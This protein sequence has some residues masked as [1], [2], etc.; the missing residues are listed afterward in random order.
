MSKQL[1]LID[2][3]YT[4]FYRFFATL[5]WV[6]LSDPDEYKKYKDDKTYDWSQ[7]T[8][9]IDKYKKM[10]LESIIKLIKKKSF[11]NSIIIFCMDSPRNTLWRNDIISSYKSDRVDL[12][13]K[14]DFKPTFQY[15][16]DK[17][18]PDIIKDH[19]NI[20]KLKV[21]NT[22]ADDIIA[23]ITMYL[24][25]NNPDQSIQIVSGDTDFLQLGRNN[26]KFINYKDKKAIELD[27]KE[28]IG[29]L[30]EKIILGDKSDNIPSIFPTDK[31]ELS[32]I[33]RKEILNDSKVLESYLISNP[34]IKKKYE[35][36]QSLIDFNYI[37]K[38]Y[39]KNIIKD[40]KL[41]VDKIK[42]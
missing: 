41:I 3:S 8:V 11:N 18:I 21:E 2:T 1:I 4:S 22:E 25:D 13:L 15:T 40:Y 35:L 36:N 14:N 37:P 39:Y 24:K 42:E 27:E 30:Y 38:K 6:S 9:F 19:K 20:Y 31:K 7:N 26:V 10:Y 34:K 5:R 33:R 16:Y 32:N 29:K 23:C 12:S 28:A 17:I